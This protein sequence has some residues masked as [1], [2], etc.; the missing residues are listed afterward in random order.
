[1]LLKGQ[2]N[3]RIRS[4]FIGG[5]LSHSWCTKESYK[6]HTPSTDCSADVK[7]SGE[8]EII[9]EVRRL[10]CPYRLRPDEDLAQG[11]GFGGIHE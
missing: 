10:G 9:W 2:L 8:L 1:M 6:A 4:N 3:D 7:E 11:I 5:K